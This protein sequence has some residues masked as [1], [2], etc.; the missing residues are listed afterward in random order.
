MSWRVALALDALLDEVNARAPDR[1]K[2]SDGSIG[3]SAHAGRG[4]DSDH[5]PWVTLAGVGIV[6]ARDFTHDPNAG[7]DMHSLAAFLQTGHDKRVKY[8]I[9]NR[10]I[11]AGT[12]GPS[13]WQWRPYSGSNPHTAHLH[14]SVVADARLYDDTRPWGWTLEDD[15]PSADEIAKAVWAQEFPRGIDVKLA[16]NHIE[17]RS[18]RIEDVL[19][20][21]AKALPAIANGDAPSAQKI[22]D[23]VVS[24]IA[25]ALG[26]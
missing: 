23:A 3:D 24:K 15:M 26:D 1:N 12:D 6:T 21:I 13:P 20:D 9:W 25:K 14:L 8:A 18:K 22:A 11:M 5:N 2:A 10:R 19:S 17:R 16:L 7:A 4:S